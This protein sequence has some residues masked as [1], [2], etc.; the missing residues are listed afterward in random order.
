MSEET[1]LT[2]LERLE[3]ERT[4][5]IEE[6]AARA[7]EASIAAAKAAQ[8]ENAMA[9]LKRATQLV[10][11][12]ASDLNE[13]P[14]A[15]PPKPSKQE[16]QPKASAQPPQKS[17]PE[18]LDGTIG[19]LAARYR[20]SKAFADL[21]FRTRRFYDRTLRQIERDLGAEKIADIDRSRIQRAYEQWS[22]GGKIA[23][24]HSLVAILRIVVGFGMNELNDKACRELKF[25]LSNMEFPRSKARREELTA[26][27]ANA[28]RAKAHEMGWHSIAFAQALQY[29]LRLRQK[30]VIGEWVPNKEDGVSEI[31]N[32]H[33]KKWLHG[34]RWRELKSEA[35][36]SLVLEHAMS[37]SGK[38]ERISLSGADMVLE[39]LKLFGE[40]PSSI[41]PMIICER[42]KLPWVD[43]DYRDMWRK[44]ADAVDVPRGVKNASSRPSAREGR[45]LN[46]HEME[47]TEKGKRPAQ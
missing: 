9:E 17:E 26:K 41:T 16:K 7:S 18:A 25:T 13:A 19:A 45:F 31:T 15:P 46:R 47:V 14:K 1:T 11:E 3:R 44:I 39:E 8:L 38:S 37:Y 43:D 32:K 22:A 28:I 2:D 29:D 40:R 35:N 4:R 6:A 33:G 10:A 27:Q 20:A 5:L 36:G 23:I 24:A 30:D 34:L 12:L 42:T 21:R